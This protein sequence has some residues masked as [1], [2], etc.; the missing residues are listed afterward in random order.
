MMR[1]YQCTQL[2]RPRATRRSHHIGSKTVHSHVEC[3]QAW[4][5]TGRDCTLWAT[6]A[7]P[8]FYLID[9]RNIVANHPVV[10]DR[11]QLHDVIARCMLENTGT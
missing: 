10:A 7:L 6:L 1:C 3:Y 2:I 8:H 11:L 4:I 9:I 5:A